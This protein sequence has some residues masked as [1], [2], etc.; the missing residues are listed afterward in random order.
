MALEIW[1][2]HHC[3]I[4]QHKARFLRYLPPAA[5]RRLRSPRRRR[6][7]PTAWCAVCFHLS[8]GHTCL[9]TTTAERHQMADAGAAARLRT[10]RTVYVHYS[11]VARTGVM[12]LR[13][14]QLLAFEHALRV[15]ICRS[16]QR[17][18]GGGRPS[19]NTGAGGVIR[20]K[21]RAYYV[22][23][24]SWCASTLPIELTQT[25]PKKRAAR[26][27][28]GGITILLRG[29]QRRRLRLLSARPRRK[30]D[31]TAA[32]LLLRPR[33]QPARHYC[34]LVVLLDRVSCEPAAR[35]L[36]SSRHKQSC[37]VS[38]LRCAA[39]SVC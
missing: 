26:C 39:A 4:A 35:G 27:D 6:R 21:R 22:Y 25:Y 9:S 15:A 36:I 34:R 33:L 38:V 19:K 7:E 10:R 18:D 29:G 23:T 16:G 28:D 12:T 20:I 5:T 11:F 32:C 1:R 37:V 2:E 8:I 13:L 31:N 17:S 3:F 14:P 24:N 30:R